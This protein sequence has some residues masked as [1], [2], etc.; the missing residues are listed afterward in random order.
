MPLNKI[1]LT[2]LSICLALILVAPQSGKSQAAAPPEVK[3]AIDGIMAVF[4]SHAL[5]GM[6]DYHGLAQEEDFY[7]SIIRDP[8]FAR[9]VE[10][11]C[12]IWRGIKPANR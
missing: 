12:G 1:R 8:R 4:Q 11:R 5:V 10:R 3:P 6:G 2:F 9:D 7:A